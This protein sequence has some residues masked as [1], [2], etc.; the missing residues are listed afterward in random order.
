MRDPK[1]LYVRFNFHPEL[2]VGCGACVTACMD[3]H[4]GFP[5]VREP[6]RR[7]YRTEYT[8]KG[9][10]AITWYSLA[11]LHCDTHECVTICPKQCFSIEQA[12]GTI[13][14]DNTSCIGCG[15]C[16]RACPYQGIVFSEKKQAEKCDG[17]LERLRMGMLPRCVAACPRH[18]ITT[19]DRPSV[20]RESQDKLKRTL[21]TKKLKR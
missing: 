17:C 21:K 20:R 19:D 4:D 15:A 6:L 8:K 7:L 1:E 13:Q 11:C 16:G 12:T 18:A 14:L 2:C 3:E 9:A 10:A 5:A